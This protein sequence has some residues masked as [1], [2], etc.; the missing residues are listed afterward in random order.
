MPHFAYTARDNE[1]KIIEGRTEAEEM[2]S[3]ANNV[4]EMGYIP[5]RVEMLPE[6]TMTMSP[7]VSDPD[8]TQAMAPP[9]VARPLTLLSGE[10]DTE[11]AS[12]DNAMLSPWERGG[13]APL[14]TP[15][16]E[17][18]QTLNAY[19]NVVALSPQ[20]RPVSSSNPASPNP[21][22]PNA[23]SA[24]SGRL[25]RPAYSES[26]AHQRDLK[27]RFL[28]TMIYPVFSGV[29][30]KE[31]VPF[32][33]QLATLIGAGLPLYQALSSMEAQT[34]NSKLKEVARRGMLQVQNGGHFSDVLAAYPWIFKP[35]E[36][37]MIRA[38]EEGG[39]LD[40]VLVQIADY[41]QHELEM[42]RIVAHE[43]LYPKIVV[44]V[45]LMLLGKYPFFSKDLAIVT[46]IVRGDGRQYLMDT[47]GFAATIL[48]PILLL[49]IVCRLFLFNV[50][51]VRE[52]YDH[53]KLKI[54]VIGGIVQMFSLARFSRTF[55]ALYRGGFTMSRALEV[56]G[57]ASGN[58]VVQKTA[59]LAVKRAE[60]GEPVSEVLRSSGIFPP[61]A[62]NMFR[63]G[64][65]SGGL[66]LMLDKLA[67]FFEG[68][69]KLKSHQAAMIFG[70]VVFLLVALLVA[71]TVITFYTGGAG[72]PPK[73]E[74]EGAALFRAVARWV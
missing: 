63:T 62:I 49:V 71:Y 70:V 54:P 21:A 38:S 45:A 8:A 69:G 31:L 13:P 56:S 11:T 7:G 48:I 22:Y 14:Q 61:M 2:T 9:S 24:E 42:K 60:Q 28:E 5:V 51:G 66:D 16:V 17:P 26:G 44:F 39:I 47:L 50:A 55:A 32:Y 33:R 74:E 35:V 64:E 41:V 53:V 6:A 10:P 52:S 36:I 46:L 20:N 25:E 23:S 72:A 30:L 27:R 43:T 1:G 29:V 12:D 3:A 34:S 68:E 18:T 57:N 73:V 4:R 65:E 15:V 19:G 40:T 37:E 59:H 58:A 67:D